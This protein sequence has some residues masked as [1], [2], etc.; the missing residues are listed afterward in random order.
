MRISKRELTNVRI[1]MVV[2]KARRR[3]HTKSCVLGRDTMCIFKKYLQ[4]SWKIF[5]ATNNLH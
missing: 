4:A 3:D 2:D 1:D 5:H